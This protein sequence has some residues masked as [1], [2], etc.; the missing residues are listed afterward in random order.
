MAA[1]KVRSLTLELFCPIYLRLRL[2]RWKQVLSLD[3][4]GPS[5]T[6]GTRFFKISSNS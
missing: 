2:G 4:K 1:P 5:I 3:Q 6:F